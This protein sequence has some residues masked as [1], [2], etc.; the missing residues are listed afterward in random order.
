MQKHHQDDPASASTSGGP[1]A[2][3]TVIQQVTVKDPAALITPGPELRLE[4]LRRDPLPQDNNNCG[5][6]IQQASQSASEAARQASQSASQ[7]IQQAQQSASEA[8]RQASQSASQG[9]QQAQQQASQSIAQASRSASQAVSSASSAIASAQSSASSAISRLN[10]SM[11]NLK[12]SASSVQDGAS[13]AVL[14]AGAAVAAATGSAAAAGSSFLAAAAKAT[15]GAASS[16]AAVGA[17]AASTVENANNDASASRI[18]AVTA[19]QAALAIVGSIIASALITILIY[20]LIIR[21][22]KKAKKRKQAN[23]SISPV[24]EYPSD[25]KFPHSDQVGT[26][27]A[28]S[29]SAYNGTRDI[30]GTRDA[31]K[32]DSEVSLSDF[33]ATPSGLGPSDFNKLKSTSVAW[34]PSNPPQAPKLGQWLKVQDPT[35]SPFG[36]IRLPTDTKSNMPLGGQL[37]SP[38][39]NS[40]IPPPSSTYR[41]SPAFVE[42]GKAKVQQA[43][44]RSVTISKSQSQRKPP[45]PQQLPPAEP[46]PPIPS[47]PKF[48]PDTPVISASKYPGYRESK[49]SVWIDD[50]PSSGIPTP[51]SPIRETRP[52]TEE[53]SQ[54]ELPASQNP[55]RTTAEWLDSIRD[56]ADPPPAIGSRSSTRDISQQRRDSR[57]SRFGYNRG[58]SNQR[59]GLGVGMGGPR[60]TRPPVGVVP[61]KSYNGEVG[62][63]KG[64]SQFFSGDEN[65]LGRMGSDSTG[66]TLNSS[67]GA[68]RRGSRRGG[69]VGRAM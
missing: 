66:G 29:Q 16:V 43:M 55:V 17:A 36:S 7:S 13:V 15:Q 14:Q 2:T 34:N 57:N 38:L 44:V 65:G 21:H 56:A 51:K 54:M 37:K 4:L 6:Q 67:P 28:A 52:A 24:S 63:V 12:A 20:F 31:P 27:I 32:N 45:P 9:I 53:T 60:S 68:S 64:L 49:A 22:Q 18:A 39:Q 26:T 35:V 1:S 59:P 42:I 5:Q 58:G 48:T 41:P 25:S 62:H 61:M 19:T 8:A 69:G 30:P 23:R 47:P 33:P 10:G 40:Y 3:V 46:S 50:V 11:D